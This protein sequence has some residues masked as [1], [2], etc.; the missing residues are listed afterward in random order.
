VRHLS[1]ESKYFRFMQPLQELT[2][3]MLVRFTQID[4][5]REMALIVVTQADD[6]ETELGVARYSINPDGESCEFALV[7][8]DEWQHRGIA[9]RLMTCLMDAARTKGLK[10]IQGEVLSNNHNMLKLMNQLRFS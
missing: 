9:H 6:K 7:I 10:I 3:I 2:P 5:D 4:Y 8:A 1:N